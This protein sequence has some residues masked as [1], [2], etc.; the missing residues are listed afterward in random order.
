MMFASFATT[1]ITPFVGADVEGLD[2]GLR[3]LN[4]TQ[5]DDVLRALSM[6]GVLRF[7]RQQLDIE[8][9]KRLGRQFGQL[10]IHTGISGMAEHPEVTKI[11]SDENSRHV[12]GELWH[13]DLSCDE[14]PPLG[15][16]LHMME[17]PT[18][19]GGDT[20]FSSSYTAYER[21]SEPMK[22]Y[23]EGLT[24]T[25]DGGVAFSRFDPDRTYPRAVHPVVT[26]HPISGRKV[27]YVNRAFTSHIN[28]IPPEEGAALLRFLCDH[29]ER[30]E[31]SMRFRWEE[32]TVAFWDN[33][34]VQHLA[35]WDY[36]PQRRLG[37]RVQ[38]AGDRKPA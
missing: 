17:V 16:I 25:H 27:L 26:H 11:Y 2:L 7:R 19:G 20:A 31:W 18:D 22:R 12:N 23:L 3:P 21:L 32:D 35:I 38:I 37:Y 14:V 9:L 24:A 4:Q 29:S 6:F 8:L 1:P 10:H 5:I 28:D 15:S 13:S 34:C 30:P 36:F 33:R